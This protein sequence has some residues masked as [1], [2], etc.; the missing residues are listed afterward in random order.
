MQIITVP[1]T[2]ISMGEEA[3]HLLVPINIFNKKRL[4]VVDTGASRTIFDKRIL[5]ENLELAASSEEHQITTIFSSS[6]AIQGI[7]PK[8]KIGKLIIKDYDAFGL[9]LDSVNESYKQM[10]HPRIDAVIGGDIFV[11]FQSEI[12]YSRL[13]LTFTKNK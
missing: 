5:E 9:D 6:S 13:E 12:S 1:I 7:I 2:L 4:A 8:F 3:F 11:Q 10:G